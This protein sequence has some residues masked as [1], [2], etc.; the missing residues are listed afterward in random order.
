MSGNVSYRPVIM[1]ALILIYF[2][3]PN[4]QSWQQPQGSGYTGGRPVEMGTM[5]QGQPNRAHGGGYVPQG[6][7][8]GQ[9][10]EQAG[11]GAHH[12]GG[13]V[14]QGRQQGQQQE[15]AGSGDPHVGG[16][17][18]GQHQQNSNGNFAGGYA[19][20]QYPQGQGQGNWQVRKNAQSEIEHISK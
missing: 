8:Q 7:Q 5:N 4:S 13:Y 9:Q 16:Y 18:S 6:R 20:N 11:S 14:P 1:D 17:V 12:G 10:Q 19:S 15:Q 2:Q 3:S